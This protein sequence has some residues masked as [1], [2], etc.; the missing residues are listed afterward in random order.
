MIEFRLTESKLQLTIDRSKIY[1]ASFYY[2][3]PLIIFVQNV[4]SCKIH[5]V[6]LGE[7]LKNSRII[8]TKKAKYKIVFVGDYFTNSLLLS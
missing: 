4:G 5:S 1:Q 8:Q 2:E 7:Y 6:T 3:I